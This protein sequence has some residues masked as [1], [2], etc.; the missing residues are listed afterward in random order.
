[1]IVKKVPMG[2]KKGP[3]TPY[4]LSQ[5][6]CEAWHVHYAHIQ[7]WCP[8]HPLSGLLSLF[9]M[10]LQCGINLCCYLVDLPIAKEIVRLYCSF[11]LHKI[12]ARYRYHLPSRD[13]P[14]AFPISYH[15]EVQLDFRRSLL[16]LLLLL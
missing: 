12:P 15:L 1:M 10:L 4:F 3:Y 2:K 16:C 5:R 13:D 8:L 14:A 7:F 11:S 9:S 6:D